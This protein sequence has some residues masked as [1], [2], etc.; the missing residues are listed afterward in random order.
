MYFVLSYPSYMTMNAL[1]LLAVLFAADAVL[2]LLLPVPHKH[3]PLLWN[4]PK[5][6]TE[7]AE[8]QL[9]RT[10]RSKGSR[11]MRGIF[12]LIFVIVIALVVAEVAQYARSHVK[13]GWGVYMVLLALSA[14]GTIP[15]SWPLPH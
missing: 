14:P 5:R 8:R 9:N 4:F 15:S 10:N 11:M 2:N 6:L 12:L 7:K 1:F 3:L 13:Y